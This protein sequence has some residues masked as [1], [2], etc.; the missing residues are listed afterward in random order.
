MTVHTSQCRCEHRLIQKGG[1][2]MVSHYPLPE[3]GQNG[4]QRYAAQTVNDEGVPSEGKKCA[5]GPRV[6]CGEKCPAIETP[7]EH[8]LHACPSPL[9]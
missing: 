6:V 4:R 8:V 5:P 3:E 7:V 1:Y 2:L 9:L